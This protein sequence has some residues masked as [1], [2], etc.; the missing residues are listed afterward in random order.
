M[1]QVGEVKTVEIH[2]LESLDERGTSLVSLTPF[3]S[4]DDLH[5]TVW[6]A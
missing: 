1:D 5:W 4:P 3:Q 6:V 2:L